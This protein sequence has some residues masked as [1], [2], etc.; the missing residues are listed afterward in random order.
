MSPPLLSR[1][2]ASPRYLVGPDDAPVLLAGSHHWDSVV[3]NAER[4]RVFDAPSFFAAL[5]RHGHTCTRLWTLWAW[6]HRIAPRI[7]ERR[8]PGLALDGRPRFDLDRIDPAFLE[9]LRERTMA[10]GAA[11]LH[12]IVMLFQGWSLAARGEGDPWPDH[13]YH[14]ANNA[15]GLDGDPAGRGD[16]SDVHRLRH[17]GVLAR[18]EAYAESVVA[19][20]GDLPHV[21]YEV[22]NESPPG[23][24]PWQRHLLAHV[25]ACQLRL[26]GSPRPCGL[27]A[28]YGAREDGALF[29]S[30]ADWVSPGGSAAWRRSPPARPPAPLPVLLDT[31][32]LWGLGGDAAWV[33]KAV[34]RGHQPLFMD[35][36][37]A[38][39]GH[40]ETRRALGAAG[41]T[42]TGIGLA[43]ARPAPELAASGYA[44]LAGDPG[45]ERLL[46]WSPRRRHAV[47]LSALPAG[48]PF[49]A[50]W[51]DPLSAAAV[52]AG[53][54]AAG[55]RHRLRAPSAG[56]ALRLVRRPAAIAAAAPP[57]APQFA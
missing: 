55:R 12:T 42:A 8:G 24:L 34:L 9:R 13:P 36:W 7:Y 21:L 44:L 35:P 40:D 31:D 50:E 37:D 51:I 33:W 3:D 45:A 46:A 57:A 5:A 20:V 2:A 22:A 48:G 10:A 27:T 18:Q 25:R 56:A 4:T 53:L 38:T 28:E 15:N 17:P 32:H 6:P 29:A 43:S 1:A 52:P 49:A 26:H 14:P 41:R 16:G 11:S 39:P 30:G 54:L 19:A 47:D 23:S